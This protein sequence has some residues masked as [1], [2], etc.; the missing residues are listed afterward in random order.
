M[1]SHLAMSLES[2]T[3]ISA[4]KLVNVLLSQSVTNKR[5]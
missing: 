2:E 3:C 1:N 4:D 5:K